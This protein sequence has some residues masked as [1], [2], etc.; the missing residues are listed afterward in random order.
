MATEIRDKVSVLGT[1]RDLL[2]QTWKDR[3]DIYE[4]SLDT[5]VCAGER[6]SGESDVP[7]SLVIRGAG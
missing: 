4:Q 5:Q 1:R 2:A 3:H 7:Q 6:L